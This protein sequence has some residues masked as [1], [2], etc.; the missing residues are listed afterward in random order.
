MTKCILIVALFVSSVALAETMEVDSKGYYV[1][2]NEPDWVELDDGRE[3]YPGYDRHLT[4]V[5]KDGK[6]ESHWCNGTNIVNSSGQEPQFEYGAGHCTV[7]DEDGD[8]Y[9][10]WFVVDGLGAFEW[11]VMGGTG[12]YK[13]ASGSGVSTSTSSS[14]DGTAVFNI[15][16]TIELLDHSDE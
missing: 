16:G 2:L 13:G 1:P 10:T 8:A 6:T 5:G 9:W 3:A 12:K 4:A 15:T 11:K 7:F 14:P